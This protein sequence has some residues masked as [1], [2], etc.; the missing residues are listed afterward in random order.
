MISGW[1]YKLRK[2][3]GFM[4]LTSQS[5]VPPGIPL[6]H[7][8]LSVTGERVG[9]AALVLSAQR[10]LG[11]VSVGSAVPHLLEVTLTTLLCSTFIQLY[12]AEGS[13]FVPL[14]KGSFIQTWTKWQ[15]KTL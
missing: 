11:D 9:A 14:Q 10:R 7:S 1:I 6:S 8:L 15:T 2:L 4:T 3:R 12:P 13:I 5:L